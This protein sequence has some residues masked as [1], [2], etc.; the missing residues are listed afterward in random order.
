MKAKDKTL[1][2]ELQN[3][4]ARL[5][6]NYTEVPASIPVRGEDM[7]KNNPE[8]TDT[9]GKP[10]D[11]KKVY[12]VNGTQK[13]PVNHYKRMNRIFR[14]RGEDGVKAYIAEV[15]DLEVH[16]M[17]PKSIGGIQTQYD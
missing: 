2:R 6:F 7:L 12:Y 1:H 11:P 13:H 3:I 17:A 8:A 9:S 14:D 16:A 4:A 15:I 5:P 10:L